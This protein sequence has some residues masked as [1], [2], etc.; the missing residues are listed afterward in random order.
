MKIK[1]GDA[2]SLTAGGFTF[3]IPKGTDFTIHEGSLKAQAEDFEPN[4]NGTG[5][6]I[7][8]APPP[9]QILGVIVRADSDDKRDFLKDEAAAEHR[10][11]ILNHLGTTFTF[12]ATAITPTPGAGI[13]VLTMSNKSETFKLVAENGAVMKRVVA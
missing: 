6:T 11:W 1:A 10:I 9:A 13:G 12:T 2:T 5:E 3:N 7:Y 8:G 4:G